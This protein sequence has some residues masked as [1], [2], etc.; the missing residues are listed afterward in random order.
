MKAYI[1]DVYYHICKIDDVYT[2]LNKGLKSYYGKIFMYNNLNESDSIAANQCFLRDYAIIK[3]NFAGINSPLKSDNVAE[4]SAYCQYFI[5][6]KL[7]LPEHLELLCYC[8]V[9]IE[10]LRADYMK[11]FARF[12]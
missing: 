1:P 7:I 10:K 12:D 2:I 11:K 5:K 3:I 9:D 4:S 8:K 6:Q